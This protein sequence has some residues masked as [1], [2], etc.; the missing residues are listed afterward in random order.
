M[1]IRYDE[2]K[3]RIGA[4]VHAEKGELC[5]A[6]FARECLELL[7]DRAVLVFPRLSL[8]DEEQLAFTDKLGP[9]SEYSKRNVSD[10]NGES[11]VYRVSLDPS[12]KMDTQYVLATYFWHMDGVTVADFD[13]PAATL[14]S[15][16]QLPGEGGQTEFAS[17]FAAYDALPDQEKAKLERMRAVHSVY[18]GVRPLLEFG[19]GPEEW[20]QAST[21]IEHPLVHTHESGRKSLVLGVQVENIVGMELPE[22]RALISRLMD[23]ATQPDFKYR[24]EWS[25][26]DLVMWKN[27][28]A[29]HRVIPYQADSGRLM[30]RTSLARLRPAA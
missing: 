22:A 10:V 14:L 4:I 7:D 27:L 6:G 12:V 28:G 1:P 3:P 13:P 11:D 30:H 2:L 18:S 25:E 29:L 16:R 23:W 19:V 24:H 20:G 9:R 5:D 21:P 17:T 15:A 8:T 26:G